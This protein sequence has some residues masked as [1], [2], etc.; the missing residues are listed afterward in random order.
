MLLYWL[1]KYMFLTIGLHLPQLQLK[2]LD[3]N[4]RSMSKKETHKM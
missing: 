4:M 2:W 1:L 3:N